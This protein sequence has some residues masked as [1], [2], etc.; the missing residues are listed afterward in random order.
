M[1]Y[2]VI[3]T[4][5]NVAS[6]KLVPEKFLYD[7][8]VN[9]QNKMQALGDRIE[10]NKLLDKLKSYYQDHNGDHLVSEMGH[11][12]IHQGIL[13]A[14]DFSYLYPSVLTPEESIELHEKICA[15]YP[16]RFHVF[17]GID[18][19]YGSDGITLFHNKVKSGSVHGLKVYPL[20]GF[21]PSDK[22][23]FPYYEI[24]EAYGLPVLSHSGPGWQDLNYSFGNPVL[25]DEA[26]RCFRG[27]NFIL[28]HGAIYNFHESSYLAVYRENVYLDCSGFANL[29]SNSLWIS[30]LKNTFKC[31]F[32]HKILF[33]T[34]WPAYK[35]TLSNKRIMDIMFSEDGPLTEL[36]EKEV[37]MIM[38]KNLL[39][40]LSVSD[41]GE[42]NG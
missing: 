32:N 4:H 7:Q 36:K 40:I 19:R 22:R 37:G 33:G 38:G 16:G 9:L 41:K 39:R 11:S 23:L 8:A 26:A 34:S 24:C 15:R 35:M 25:I 18:P 1:P 6:D 17:A 21:S 5:I 13:I 12:G 27:V 31:G 10:I 2:T 20:C 30:H 14:P 3:D 42:Q 28:G 29:G